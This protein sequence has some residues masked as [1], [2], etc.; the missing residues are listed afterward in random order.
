MC[1]SLDQKCSHCGEAHE[2]GSKLCHMKIM[3]REIKT[4]QTLR[5]TSREQAIV[6]MQK[7]NP[8]YQMHYSGA[9]SRNIQIKGRVVEKV[10]ECS[11]GHGGTR[12]RC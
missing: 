11:I 6:L 5:K 4:I 8:E 7:S 1:R 9:V 12:W 10:E 3:E 2:T